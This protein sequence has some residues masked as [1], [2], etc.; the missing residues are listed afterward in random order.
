MTLSE[1][2]SRNKP[3]SDLRLVPMVDAGGGWGTKGV[4][5]TNGRKQTTIDARIVLFFNEKIL[6][7]P[8]RLQIIK[9]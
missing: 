5:V 2:T 9:S 6:T 3:N 1:D 4:M 8:F 7:T